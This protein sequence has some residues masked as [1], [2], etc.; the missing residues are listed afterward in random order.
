MKLL[1]DVDTMTDYFRA[2]LSQTE[3]EKP[4]SITIKGLA[5]G[6]DPGDEDYAD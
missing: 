6:V 3:L 4:A 5:I 1:D 2:R